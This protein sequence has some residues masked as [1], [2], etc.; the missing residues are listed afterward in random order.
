MIRM[1]RELCRAYLDRIRREVDPHGAYYPFHSSDTDHSHLADFVALLQ[2]KNERTDLLV[3]RGGLPQ[4]DFEVRR[5]P[6]PRH[7]APIGG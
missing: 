3:F 7:R 6:Q 4:L 5:T 2:A 1:K